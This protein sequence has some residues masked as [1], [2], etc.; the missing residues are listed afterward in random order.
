[1]I[2]RVNFGG[3]EFAII[4][5]SGFNE[6]GIHFFT[7]GDFSQQLGYMR[8][9]AGHVIEPHVHNSVHR[10]V[11]FTREALFLR[12]GRLRVDFYTDDGDYVESRELEAGDVILLAAGGHGF[13]ALE[14]IEMIEVKQ[15]PYIGDADKTRIKGIPASKVRILGPCK[16]TTKKQS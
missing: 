13:E 11:H 5:R 10:S 15:G 8:R 1:M 2:E 6:P 12:R 7:P 4:V 14:E 16:S 9:P 3:V